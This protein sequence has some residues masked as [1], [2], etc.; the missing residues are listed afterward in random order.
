[1]G[2]I[3]IDNRSEK[4]SDNDALLF[5]QAVIGKGRVSNFGKQYCY[6]SVW[7]QYSPE[8]EVH[9]VSELNKKSDRFIIYTKDKE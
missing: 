5:V 4:L 9:V 2:K 7:E 1:M 3:I 8:F 6:V